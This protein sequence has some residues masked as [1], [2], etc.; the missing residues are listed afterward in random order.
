MGRRVLILG[1]VMVEQVKYVN[2]FGELYFRYPLMTILVCV[3]VHVCVHVC[4]V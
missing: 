3:C 1:G 2:N 4:D